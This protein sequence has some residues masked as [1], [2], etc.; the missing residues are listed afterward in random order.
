[1]N[2]KEL[3]KQDSLLTV[4]EGYHPEKYEKPTIEIL[5]IE[6]AGILASSGDDYKHGGSWS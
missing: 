3:N 5:E 2:Q 6:N 4:N 1:M